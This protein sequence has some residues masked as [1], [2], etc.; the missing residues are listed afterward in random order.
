MVLHNLKRAGLGYF[1]VICY[2]KCRQHCRTMSCTIG[3]VSCSTC[4]SHK[5]DLPVRHEPARDG[6]GDGDQ[7]EEGRDD[8]GDDEADLGDADLL[9]ARV[10]RAHVRPRASLTLN[11]QDGVRLDLGRFSCGFRCSLSL[12]K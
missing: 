6:D 10:P 1:L 4:E 12:V 2:V 9:V 8:E 5:P 11:R 7:R 3:I